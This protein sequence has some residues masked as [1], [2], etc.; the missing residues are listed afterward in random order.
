MSH[1]TKQKCSSHTIQVYP[2]PTNGTAKITSIFTE[3]ITTRYIRIR[4]VEW[5]VKPYDQY[6]DWMSL[7][8]ELLGCKG[9]N[10]RFC[11]MVSSGF[12]SLK[13]CTNGVARDDPQ[14]TFSVSENI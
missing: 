11:N 13:K 9:K 14:T 7:R 2:G 12:G 6:N 5:L 3:P 1:I 4:P 10:V 8:M